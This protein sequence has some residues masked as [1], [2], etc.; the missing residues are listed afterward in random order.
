VVYNAVTCG[1]KC[2]ACETE[3]LFYILHLHW[4]RKGLL[5]LLKVSVFFFLQDCTNEVKCVAVE[6]TFEYKYSIDFYYLFSFH[7]LS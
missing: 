1:H 3:P 4:R 7:K 6:Q 2:I 5:L